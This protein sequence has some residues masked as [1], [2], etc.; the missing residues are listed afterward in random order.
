MDRLY[1][2]SNSIFSTVSRVLGIL[3]GHRVVCVWSVF[4]DYRQSNLRAGRIFAANLGFIGVY[5]RVCW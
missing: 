1:S 5:R 3:R 2:T 4:A